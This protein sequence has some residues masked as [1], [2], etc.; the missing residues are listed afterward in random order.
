MAPEQPRRYTPDEVNAILKRAL[1]RQAPAGSV[2]QEE[3]META[4]ELGI[5]PSQVES[6][7]MEQ[8]TVGAMEAAREEWK[9][10]QKK[11]FFE[12]LRS[13]AIVNIVLFMINLMTGGHWFFWPLFGWGIGLLFHASGA[14]FPK[15]R[16]IERGARRL[17]EKQGRKQMKEG[18]RTSWQKNITL[19]SGNGKIVIEKGDKRIEIG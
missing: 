18:S 15:E 16:D 17:L 8:E 14:F 10:R 7:I 3:L 19:N 5:D 6:A 13:Y 4:R 11:E 2:T 9:L 12:H 1:D